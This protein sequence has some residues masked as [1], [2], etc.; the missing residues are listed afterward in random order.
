MGLTADQWRKVSPWSQLFRCAAFKVSST[1]PELVG[2][3]W[4]S[5]FNRKKAVLPRIDKPWKLID[6]TTFYITVYYYF[7]IFTIC[8]NIFTL[9]VD[10]LT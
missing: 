5:F 6:Y 2:T 7:D 3:T 8:V 10:E 4:L 9:H 1:A